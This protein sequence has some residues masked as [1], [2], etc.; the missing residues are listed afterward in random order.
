MKEKI[1]RKWRK[2]Y[3]KKLNRFAKKLAESQKDY[4]PEF[5]KT[6]DDNFWELIEK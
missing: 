3:E 4:P 5:T 2:K 1:K 6:V